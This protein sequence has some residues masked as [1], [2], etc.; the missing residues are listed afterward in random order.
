MAS[1]AA[2]KLASAS[3]SVTSATKS[4]VPPAVG[5]PEITPVAACSL[6]PAGSD[7]TG[8]DQ[9]YGATP[10]VAASVAEYGTPAVAAGSVTVV[11]VSGVTVTVMDSSAVAEA[12][13]LSESV[14]SAMKSE[15][16]AGPR[17]LPVISPVAACST[18]PAGSVVPPA[19][20]QE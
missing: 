10:P 5:V 17:G 14:T 20:D 16:P 1:E 4:K 19:S 6:S 11:T 18:S 12:G 2:E 9:L 7:P 3:E 13:E 15:V 8:I